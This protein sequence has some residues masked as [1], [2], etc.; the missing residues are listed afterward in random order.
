MKKMLLLLTVALALAACQAA[1][2]GGSEKYVRNHEP[3]P[4][5]PDL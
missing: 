4:G 5:G 1:S 3:K 2:E